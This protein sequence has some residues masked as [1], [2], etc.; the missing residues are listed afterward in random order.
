MGLQP[1]NFHYKGHRLY[2]YLVSRH[3]YDTKNPIN[4]FTDPFDTFSWIG[5][6]I[7]ISIIIIGLLIILLFYKKYS[8]QNLQPNLEPYFIALK[9]IFGFTE[10][11]EVDFFSQRTIYSSGKNIFKKV[12]YVLIT[13]Y[14][15]MKVEF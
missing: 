8:P 5:L 14:N 13:N 6:G 12:R 4:S 2:F 11:D 10:P 7:I 1:F 15:N 3:P 9:L